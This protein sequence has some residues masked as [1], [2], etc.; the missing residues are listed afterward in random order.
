[1][2][3]VFLER[4]SK[5]FELQHFCQIRI[6]LKIKKYY[7]LHICKHSFS[8]PSGTDISIDLIPY[9]KNVTLLGRRIIPGVPEK[10]TQVVGWPEKVSAEK[11]LTNTDVSIDCDVVILASGYSFDFSFLPE[12]FV[13][14]NECKKKINLLYRQILHAKN[15]NLG[16]IG[17]E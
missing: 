4:L 15:P 7:S 12:E 2:N 5:V 3:I 11:V 10:I 9:A 6:S 13:N 1:M 14:L 17:N 16:F 8:G